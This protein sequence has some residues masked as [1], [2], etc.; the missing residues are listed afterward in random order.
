MTDMHVTAD[1]T[2][3]P[4]YGRCPDCREIK[5]VTTDGAVQAHNAYHA[6]GTNTVVLRCPGSDTRPFD[7]A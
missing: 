3:T 2:V 1:D 7:A 5:Q 4:G 6:D